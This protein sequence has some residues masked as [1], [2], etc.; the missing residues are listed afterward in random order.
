[1]ETKL[2]LRLWSLCLFLHLAAMMGKLLSTAGMVT[3]DDKAECMVSSKEEGL[4]MLV[5]V[6]GAEGQ[7][8]DTRTHY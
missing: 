6:L 2:T 8:W 5:E 4:S 3:G 7:V 1:M